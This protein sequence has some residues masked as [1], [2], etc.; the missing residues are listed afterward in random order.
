MSSEQ[1]KE[2]PASRDGLLE[3]DQ[4]EAIT[5]AVSAIVVTDQEEDKPRDLATLTVSINGVQL[6]WKMDFRPDIDYGDIVDID[7][8]FEYVL[9]AIGE[10]PHNIESITKE[11]EEAQVFINLRRLE[12]MRAILR[13]NLEWDII[14]R[15]KGKFNNK[16]FPL[17]PTETFYDLYADLYVTPASSQEEQELLPPPHPSKE[18]DK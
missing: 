1:S 16:D 7:F 18:E 8:L 12:K 14:S 17:L 11:N 4:L 9:D 2:P 5:E 10:L 6:I 13:D 3:D 15:R